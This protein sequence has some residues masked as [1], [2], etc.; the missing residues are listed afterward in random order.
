MIKLFRF[1]PAGDGFAYSVLPI[2][3]FIARFKKVQSLNHGGIHV[4]RL[5]SF[6]NSALNHK[7]SLR[8]AEAAERRIRR[9]VGAAG[10]SSSCYVRNK[11]RI[12][13][14]KK[15]AFQNGR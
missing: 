4:Q 11:I 3:K 10:I 5:G 9:K 14:M 15:R 7:H 2:R 12:G 1:L 8:S 13:A 6:C